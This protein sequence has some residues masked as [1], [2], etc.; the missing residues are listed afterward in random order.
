M[1]ESLCYYHSASFQ[2][3][4]SNYWFS[5]LSLDRSWSDVVLF[6][7]LLKFPSHSRLASNLPSTSVALITVPENQVKTPYPFRCH[8]LFH[9]TTCTLLME[10]MTPRPSRTG[11]RL[12]AVGIFED[13][14]IAPETYL[15]ST[16]LSNSSMYISFFSSE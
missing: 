16:N 9:G 5:H 7:S 11:Q 2:E 8:H 15:N 14:I 6:S 3:C 10:M 12:S 4:W 1:L 13:C